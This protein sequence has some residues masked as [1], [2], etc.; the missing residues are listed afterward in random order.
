M[1]RTV[2]TV[3]SATATA[4]DEIDAISLGGPFGPCGSGSSRRRHLRALRTPNPLHLKKPKNH[5][6]RVH[7]EYALANTDSVL[8]GDRCA[9]SQASGY[10]LAAG[11][12]ARRQRTAASRRPPATPPPP[13]HHVKRRRSS[14]LSVPRRLRV[15]AADSAFA[16]LVD[17]QQHEHTGKP[18]PPPPRPE[19]L[20]HFDLEPSPRPPTYGAAF[21]DPP[22]PMPA[23]ESPQKHPAETYDGALVENA[24]QQLHLQQGGRAKPKSRVRTGRLLDWREIDELRGALRENEVSL[25][26]LSLDLASREVQ[27]DQAAK[28]GESLV[29]EKQKTLRRLREVVDAAPQ[30]RE[31][32]LSE[33]HAAVHAASAALD[34]A[35][36]AV[37]LA[38]KA[39]AEEERIGWRAPSKERR[40]LRRRQQR[41]GGGRAAE[42]EE[43]GALT[44]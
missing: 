21:E 27:V 4:A 37:V 18:V 25:H 3:V 7:P 12:H 14:Q 38:R 20:V 41:D 2:A 9:K 32:R 29:L 13:L 5:V 15:S 31:A 16:W 6:R 43:G 33:L 10:S 23:F 36:S 1:V 44:G 30:K 17:P 11:M 24:G 26:R 39:A 40:P 19:P 34:E 28:Q 22:S 8:L 42:L 35:R